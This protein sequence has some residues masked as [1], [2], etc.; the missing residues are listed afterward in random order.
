MLFLPCQAALGLC[1]QEG[2]SGG[3][4]HPRRCGVLGPV[5]PLPH[6]VQPG[7]NA[8]LSAAPESAGKPQDTS[9]EPVLLAPSPSDPPASSPAQPP[10]IPVRDAW[11]GCS[12]LPGSPDAWSAQTRAHMGLAAQEPLWKWR[13][14]GW[15]RG[16][17]GLPRT[18]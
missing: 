12:S 14:S 15:R 7:D 13:P 6:A 8:R 11:R 9:D 3:S 16:Q 1:L 17:P 18:F 4:A 5:A 10:D 2:V